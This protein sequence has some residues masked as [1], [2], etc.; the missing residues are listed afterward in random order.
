MSRNSIGGLWW[1]AR[2]YGGVSEGIRDGQS[3]LRGG[4]EYDRTS[5]HTQR[6][7]SWRSR[8]KTG[9]VL[10]S[11]REYRGIVGF[12]RLWGGYQKIFGDCRVHWRIWLGV[13]VSRSI[14]GVWWCTQDQLHKGI[15]QKDQEL[16]EGTGGV[17][18][19]SRLWE[20]LLEIKGYY[21]V[22]EGIGWVQKVIRGYQRVQ[23]EYRG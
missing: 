20:A 21:R 18:Q 2:G 10:K 13:R 4:K 3:V 19:G 12:K 9:C 16:L 1:V 6:G 22:W 15:W 11:I 17:S 5:D 14:R 7:L 23:E 8:G